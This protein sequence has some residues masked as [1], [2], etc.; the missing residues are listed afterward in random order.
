M[1]ALP[2]RAVSVALC[3]FTSHALA[4]PVISEFVADNETGITDENGDRSDWLE[5]HN[6]DAT[7]V[8]LDGWRLTDSA[9]DLA[10]W[11]FPAVTLQPGEFLII[12]ASAKDRRIAG[13]PLHTNFSLRAEGEFLGLVRP[14][15]SISQQFAPEFPP[16]DPDESYGLNFAGTTIVAQGISGRYI[17]PTNDA[18]GV[19]WT[20]TGFNHNNWSFGNTGLGFGLLVPGITVRSVKKD[21]AY[22]SLT[23]IAEIEALL[24]QPAGSP[25]ILRDVTVVAQMVNYLGEGSDGHYG[26]NESFPS[27]GPDVHCIKA[28]GV[29]RIPTAGAW[30]FGLNSD[31]GGRIRIDGR[32]V[33]VDDTN[34]GPE[35]H[36]GTVTLTAGDH[37]FE[38][39][40]WEGFGGDEVE[41]YA[42][43]GS[44]TSWNANMRLVGD[45]ANGGLAAFTLPSGATSGG[46]V[47]ATNIDSAM[48]NVNSGAFL[49][50]PFSASNISGFDSL[51]LKMRYNDGFVAYL[52]GTEIARRNAPA[53]ALN[54]NA[55]A[56]ASRTS[57]QSLTVEPINVTAFLPQLVNGSNVLAVHGLNTSASD[58]SFL[59]L[60]ELVGGGLTGGDPVFF[61]QTTPGS[62][63]GT[64]ASLG[65]VADT[66]FSHNRGFYT[67]PFQVTISTT[68]AGA[69]IRYTTDGSTPTEANGTLYAA[70]VTINRTTVLRAVAFKAGWEPTDADTQTYIF[71]EDVLTQSASGTP[72]PGWPAGTVNGQVLDY[73][74]DPE[75]VNHANP[76]IGGPTMIKNALQAIPTVSLVS[77]VPNF[78]DSSEGIYV[79]PGGRGFAWERPCSIELINDPAGGFQVNAGMRIRGGFSRSGG[80]PKHAFHFYF[81]GDYGDT[82]LRYP[83]FGRAGADEFD[84]IDLRTSQNY[85]WSFGGDSNNTFLREE[86]SRVTQGAMGQ[87]YARLRYFHLY[88]NGQ[89]WGLFN[90]EERTEASYAA[91]YLGGEKEDWDI[92][93]NE[94]TA[95]YTVGATD[96]NL[97]G[98]QELWTKARAHASNP[99]NASYFK[100]MG[101]AADGV[102]P[103]ADPVLLDVDNLI[104]YNLLTFWTGN[105]DGATSSFLG[106]DKA[107]NWFAARRRNGTRG[108]AFFAHDFEH[109]L[110]LPGGGSGV[111]RTGPFSD[112]NN[113]RNNF[114]YSNPYFLHLDLLGTPAGSLTAGSFLEYRVRFGDRTHQHLF[115]NGAL[116]QNEVVSR[117]DQL[118]EIVDPVIAAESA[119]W[120]D[121]KRS[122]PLTRLDWEGARDRMLND[123]ALIR[124]DILV[125]QLRADGLYPN[126][127]APTISQFGGYLA[128][129]SEVLMGTP[130]GTTYYTLD[131]SDPRLLGGGL[132]PVA[133][134]YTSNT[135]SEALVPLGATWK[136]LA[137]GTNQGVA[138]RAPTFDDS[139]WSSG[140]AELGY[141]DGDE[142][143]TVPFV[144]SNPAVAGVQK[145]ATTYFRRTF[146]VTNA[147]G[148]NA[149]NLRVDYD[150][151]A[152]VY[153]NGQVATRFGNIPLDPAFD[154]YTNSAI[155]ETSATA[156]ISPALLREGANTIAV[157]VHQADGSSSDISMNL[158]LTG[159][160]TSTATPLILNGAGEKRLRVRARNGTEWSAL[161]DALFLVDAEPA[162]GG[163][164]AITEIMYHPAEPSPAE[165]AAG[166]N[167]A[168]MFEYLEL[169][170]TGTK[171]VDL[172]GLYFSSGIEFDFASSLL[173]RLLAPGG[174]L[175]LVANRAAFELRYGTGKA[176]AGEFSGSLNN[177]GDLLAFSNAL[178]V[179]LRSFSYDDVSPWPS[180]ADG[181]G[182]SLVL[183]RAGAGTDSSLASN[184]R[185]SSEIGGSPGGVDSTTY[186]LWKTANGVVNDAAD[187]DA[188]GVPAWFEYVLGGSATA[189]DAPREPQSGSAVIDVGGVPQ[190]YATLTFTRRLTADDV[191]L[192]IEKSTSLAPEAWTPANSVLVSSTRNT[193][194]TETF[195]YRAPQ[196]LPSTGQEFL[197]LRA[198]LAP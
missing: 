187:D 20:A 10:K 86:F 58:N 81:R 45:T 191:D 158:S 127:D 25:Q 179:T 53:G 69:Q 90:T 21:P 197:R 30:T 176:I 56:T 22:G 171:H 121:A 15:G 153:I 35:D 159:V 91:E 109:S 89:Y 140:V 95:G 96:G 135:T 94:Q 151:A 102:T 16:Q 154:Y 66:K 152:I 169:T 47:I 143:T 183:R 166:F 130:V 193:D 41:F 161:V 68:T 46:A 67:A 49:R 137:N 124:R 149:L 150:D 80:N 142:A 177:A 39:I 148:I 134:V 14:D 71:L 93:K 163:N 184:W 132:N 54:Y 76:E 83:L 64:P 8:N 136:Y 50:L 38:V 190:R 87:P 79:N 182:Y 119:R 3:L 167:D 186:A 97:T 88:L 51:T 101:L 123:F 1:L 113:N 57:D 144:D 185:T 155:E 17:V 157:E 111:D 196:P 125:S 194:G 75:I 61:T 18:L 110:G 6:P 105:Q 156:A 129:G 73:G 108:F 72:P 40:M 116:S 141:G 100:M 104:D 112:S 174:R 13:S 146:N 147:A 55:T 198:T 114:S 19:T 178:E 181:A 173:P 131:G 70:P 118:A 120:G 59:I 162:T 37:T 63:N 168:N 106:N 4:D 74:M 2:L 43:S 65:K 189:N 138:W 126:L 164:L 139:S 99:T 60:P 128:S 27:G 5:L 145:N 82:K 28:T 62:I 78:F 7:P 11:R 115:N 175:L 85:S 44:H 33:M 117:I 170:N 133:Q 34:H 31:D 160:R 77:D 192:T 98:W 26:G 122:S 48:R 23:S 24:A 84:Q 36:L 32:D 9:G 92:I 42:G 29:V 180:E 165:I 172:A 103:T 195:V 52:N 188:D 12:W 107:N